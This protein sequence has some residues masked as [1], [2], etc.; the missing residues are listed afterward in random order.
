MRTNQTHPRTGALYVPTMNRAKLGLLGALL[1]AVAACSPGPMPV[2]QSLRDPSNPSA[3]EG[4]TPAVAS[5]AP[6]APARA[7]GAAAAGH[8]HGSHEHAA[9]GEGVTYVCPMHPEV[10][11]STPGT[12]PK[13]NMKLVPKK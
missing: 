6:S 13:C 5:A 8:D 7:G 1:A 4:V 3:P 10:T 12:C 11:S 2:S 9:P